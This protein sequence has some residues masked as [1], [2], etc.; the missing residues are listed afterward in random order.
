MNKYDDMNKHDDS[1]DKDGGEI[2]LLKIVA[3]RANGER[4]SQQLE[5]VRLPVV[6]G[7]LEQ[8]DTP[9][10]DCDDE[11]SCSQETLIRTIL[12]QRQIQQEKSTKVAL[13]GNKYTT[14]TKKKQKIKESLTAAT[15]TEDTEQAPASQPH[16]PGAYAVAS[17]IELQRA[18][19]NHWSSMVGH[20]PPCINTTCCSHSDDDMLDEELALS[21]PR[22]VREQNMVRQVEPG[23]VSEPG[24]SEC[25]MR[26]ARDST[27]ST[28]LT[29]TA[30]QEEDISGLVVANPVQEDLPWAEAARKDRQHDTNRQQLK[31]GKC[32]VAVAF[33]IVIMVAI[34]AAFLGTRTTS[35]PA[36]ASSS[37]LVSSTSAPSSIEDYVLTLLNTETLQSILED[38]HSS[39]AQAFRWL[40]EDGENLPYLSVER[41]QQKFALA[42]LYYSTNGDSWTTN[43]GWLD[44]SVHECEWFQA[45][46][47]A[48]K[49]RL[50]KIYPGYLSEFFPPS[51]PPPKT[52]NEN[53]L[54]QH[55]WLDHN[56]LV[57]SLPEELYMLTLLQTLSIGHNQLQG[58]LSPKI[59]QLTALEGFYPAGMIH[60]AALP[61]E[62]GLLT[63]LRGLLLGNSKYPETIP[64]ELWQL[65][66][67][68]TL[69]VLGRPNMQGSIPTEIASFSKLKWFVIE[70][71]GLTG[72]L[73]TELGQIETLEWLMIKNNRLSGTLPTELSMI[74]NMLLVTLNGNDLVGKLPSELG[75]LTSL[76]TLIFRRNHFTGTV[77]TEIGLLTNLEIELN[78]RTNLMTGIVPSELG[79]LT[80][81]HELYL[82]NNQLSGQIPSELGGLSSTLG[83]LHLANNSFSGAIPSELSR[84]QQSLHSISLDGNPML[85]GAVPE[86][87]CNLNGSCVIYAQKLDPCGE[88][89]GVFL[90][91]TDMLCGCG[92]PC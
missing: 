32:L 9:Q 79:R 49:E 74:P 29:L 75:L 92:C 57:G 14:G 27:M 56:N 41:V 84:L 68:Q 45:P 21:P 71:C 62:I 50:A 10:D 39:Q 52:C 17:G 40:M 12:E 61:S 13:A 55:F 22:L 38:P 5:P 18:S 37:S 46:D 3:A 63:K 2:N 77:P 6:V 26:D 53:G 82:Q 67:L 89:Q 1:M 19:T 36:V 51:E 76:T 69:V 33:G 65:T 7:Q 23:A 66:N 48:Q 59:G 24:G 87:I 20:P 35:E 91:C 78:L 16:C 86:A 85:S 15:A 11:A 58:V 73:P 88:P 28:S 4:V 34:I 47:F 70:D 60:E 72:T 30:L 90:D 54:Y 80:G 83:Y 8:E 64:T 43:S 81:L 31:P 42:T 44:H 25:L